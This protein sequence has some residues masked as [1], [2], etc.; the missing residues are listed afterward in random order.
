M[1]EK[2]HNILKYIRSNPDL[3]LLQ[4]MVLVLPFERIPSID[5]SFITLRPSLFIGGLLI[6]RG[7]WILI[8]SRKSGWLPIEIVLLGLFIL[9]VSLIIPISINQIRAIQVVLYTVFAIGVGISVFYLWKNIGE[10]S[11]RKVIITLY[12]AAI[13]T[14]VFG[15]YQYF[16]DFF[17]LNSSW[18]G[19]SERYSW[20]VFG[21]ARIQSTGLEPLY[22][23]SYL[24]LP[25]LL[26]IN[27]VLYRKKIIRYSGVV[28]TL[29]IA[30]LSLTLSRGAIYGLIGA[31]ILTFVC[32]AIYRRKLVSGRLV[33]VALAIA[34]GFILALSCIQLF[35]RTPLI[36]DSPAEGKKAAGAYVQQLTNSGVEGSGDD[37]SRFRLKAIR[38]STSDMNVLLFGIG[39]GQF[40]PYIQ[41]PNAVG[42]WAIVNNLPLEILLETGLVGLILLLTLIIL[43]VRQSIMYLRRPNSRDTYLVA[44]LLTY[45]FS[46][47]IQAQ[48]F[49][50]LYIMHI[51]VAIGLLMG[52][53]VSNKDNLNGQAKKIK[54]TTS[55]N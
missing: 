42:G 3:T 43:L 32:T 37:R 9:W 33:R 44:G 53:V 22:F 40:G 19:L 49:S 14:S 41:G 1:R 5:V 12:I 45:I 4:G 10:L 17:G 26:L 15:I 38:L 55:K 48:T 47:L 28:L 35:N 23:G 25:T 30:T 39:P 27:E 36:S 46:Q 2:I 31:L 20:R 24:L 52:V 50:T 18:T 54:N 34:I 6:L 29:F 8:K 11:R 7:L 51:W 16:G 13:I 21:F